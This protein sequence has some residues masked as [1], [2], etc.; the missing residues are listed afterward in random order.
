[1]SGLRFNASVMDCPN[2]FAGGEVEK[3]I[4]WTIIALP[5]EH[6]AKCFGGEFGPVLVL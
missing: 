6:A 5:D 1:M 3:P 2:K 4:A